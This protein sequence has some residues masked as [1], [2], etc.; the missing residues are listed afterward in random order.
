MKLLDAAEKDE[1]EWKKMKLQVAALT[2]MKTGAVADKDLP[3][4]T[5]PG[6]AKKASDV[7]GEGIY[8]Q[9]I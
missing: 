5:R 4:A 1:K 6:S 8:D 2:L 9:N 3:A 7:E